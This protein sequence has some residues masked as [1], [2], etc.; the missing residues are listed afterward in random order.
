MQFERTWRKKVFTGTG[1]MPKA[2][3][4]EK[5]LIEKVARTGGAIGYV[6]M[7]IAES[8]ET[9]QGTDSRVKILPVQD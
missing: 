3:K 2:V 8:S 6:S 9:I 7:G 4:T 1:S 5:S